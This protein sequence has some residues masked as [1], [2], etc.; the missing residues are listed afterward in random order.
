MLFANKIYI[1][2]TEQKQLFSSLCSTFLCVSLYGTVL[3]WGGVYNRPWHASLDVTSSPEKQT[4]TDPGT[5]I[6]QRH[7]G[8]S[9]HFIY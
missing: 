6:E 7:A 8:G 3:A 4:T 5:V 1:N 2:E 9:F